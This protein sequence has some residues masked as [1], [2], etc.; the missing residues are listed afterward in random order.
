MGG[1]HRQAVPARIAHLAG[2]GVGGDGCIL[3]L[4]DAD[5]ALHRPVAA[6]EIGVELEQVQR[7]I[8]GAVRLAGDRVHVVRAEV[9]RLAVHAGKAE[10]LELAPGVVD[11]VGE[12]RRL[13]SGRALGAVHVGH[14]A[15]DPPLAA[16]VVHAG[17][18]V[19]GGQ[20]EVE[21]QVVGD[22]LVERG[23]QVFVARPI[24]DLARDETG[25]QVAERHRHAGLVHDRAAVDHGTDTAVGCQRQAPLG[26]A[27]HLFLEVEH[28]HAEVRV[29]VVVDVVTDRVQELEARAVLRLVVD[30]GGVHLAADH[31]ALEAHGLL[32]VFECFGLDDDAVEVLF[33]LRRHAAF[34][35]LGLGVLELL[36]QGGD[37]VLERLLLLAQVVE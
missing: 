9:G 18:G 19:G 34:G 16:G 25:L 37:L 11:P 28:R 33:L 10:A 5:L 6:D 32:V 35:G 20:G 8:A 17:A 24:R 3:L 29:V 23:L 21:Q 27:V 36:L 4:A 31:Q 14:H 15:A 12:H 1:Q 30:E 26:A 7:G 2:G 22:Q 13:F